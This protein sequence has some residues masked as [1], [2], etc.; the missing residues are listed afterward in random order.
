[1]D[2]IKLSMAENTQ[3]LEASKTESTS[4]NKGLKQLAVKG[5]AWYFF[6]YG[7][8]QFLR[9]ASNLILT[10]LLMPNLFGVMTIV[11]TLLIG[12]ALFSDMGIGASIV[13][14][15]RGDTKKFLDTAWT[16]QILRGIGV[17]FLACVFALPLASYF[18]QPIFLS[19][20]PILGLSATIDGFVSTKMH[21][22]S[23]NLAMREFMLI[24]LVAYLVQLA[25]MISWAYIRPSIWAL[26][27]GGMVQSLVYM[28]LSHVVFEG[29]RNRLLFD[30]TV[31]KEMYRFG[32]WIMFSTAMTFLTRQ[33]DVLLIGKLMGTSF[34]GIFTTAL[35]FSRMMLD[36]IMQLGSRIL[37]PS[38]S[39][40]Q[41][42]NPQKLY[43][44]V[45]QFRLI[46]IIMTW[47]AA[48]FF[49]FFGNQF[50]DLLFNE[51]YT[52][53]GWML[54]ILSVGTL[55]SVVSFTYD[56][57]L[58][59]VGRT[60]TNAVLL[61]IQLILQVSAMYI[62]AHYFGERG[63]VTALSLVGWLIYPFKAAWLHRIKMWQPE[64][65]LPAM[66]AATVFAILFHIHLIG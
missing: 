28:T 63:I 48:M 3:Y 43:G 56:N 45:R 24:E 65:D 60:F 23:R 54:R 29:H 50:I 11:N 30:K 21:T 34:L 64:L 51:P 58:V 57:V 37:F 35:L 61:A 1:M 62:G 14:N 40:V 19:V 16:V 46:V 15:P 59:A 44:M 10:R 38:Y 47:C 9:L 42:D 52:Q 32:R 25:V 55:M 18:E 8:Q 20:I 13:Q 33:S 49:I 36:G 66:I 7:T 2:R 31:L 17:S 6:S 27:A 39:H 5:A 12:L 4:T 53:A 26:V 22:A 41:R